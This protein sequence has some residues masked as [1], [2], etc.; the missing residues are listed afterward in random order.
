MNIITRHSFLALFLLAAVR[1]KS[2]SADAESSMR[3]AVAAQTAAP[4]PPSAPA[5]PPAAP[6]LAAA[7]FG[8]VMERDSG[9]GLINTSSIVEAEYLELRSGKFVNQAPPGDIGA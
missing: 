6:M 1:A 2:G 3:A 5:T 4:Q 8:P 7:T 9:F